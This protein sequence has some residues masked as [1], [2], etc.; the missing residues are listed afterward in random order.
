[1]TATSPERAAGRRK[2]DGTHEVASH[3]S[4]VLSHRSASWL[5]R[6]TMQAMGSVA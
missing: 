4:S 3:G 1:M 5:C 6:Q 2:E